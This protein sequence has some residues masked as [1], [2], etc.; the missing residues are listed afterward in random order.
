M[1]INPMDP[2][3]D[4]EQTAIDR[5]KAQGGRVSHLPS[6]KVSIEYFMRNEVEDFETREDF[7]KT[8]VTQTE[9]VNNLYRLGER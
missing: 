8:F 4:I 5:A 9:L 6:G 1:I 3:S 7:I 2:I